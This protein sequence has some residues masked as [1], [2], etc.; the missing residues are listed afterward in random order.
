MSFVLDT[1][2]ISEVRKG[3]KH[4]NHHVWRWYDTTP[5]DELYLSVIVLGEI[6]KG[7]EL[8]RTSDPAATASLERWLRDLR[9]TFDQRILPVGDKVGDLWGRLAARVKVSTTDGLIAATAQYYRMTVVTRNE[10]DFQRL[11][12]DYF[13]PFNGGAP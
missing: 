13:N 1:N 10:P 7:A 8:K 9:A 5:F 12:V 4:C 2:V 3:A 6:R 11:G